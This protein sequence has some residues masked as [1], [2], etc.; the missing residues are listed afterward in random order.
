MSIYLDNAATTPLC[1]EAREAMVAA[2]DL[3]GNPSSTHAEGRK[4]K[5]LIEIGRA[6][7]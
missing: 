2:L 5:A 4:S 7:V 3:Y 6:H 1:P